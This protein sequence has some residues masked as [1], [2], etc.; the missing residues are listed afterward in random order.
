M[1]HKYHLRQ[2]VCLARFGFL[3]TRASASGLYEVTRLMP[4]DQTGEVSYRIKSS[5]GERA[6]RESEI[7][8]PVSDA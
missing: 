4:A 6:V 2:L 8:A 7:L 3:D 5:G 1:S